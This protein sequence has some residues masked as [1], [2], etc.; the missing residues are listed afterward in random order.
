[1]TA[2]HL[3][4]CTRLKKLGFTTGSQMR[5]YGEV[6]ELLSEPIV[7]ADDTVLVDATEKKSGRSRRVPLPLPIVNMASVSRDVAA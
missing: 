1:M 2:K 7:M 4:L 3:G 6:F 5:L